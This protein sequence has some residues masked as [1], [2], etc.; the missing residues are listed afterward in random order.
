MLPVVF[1]LF[2]CRRVSSLYDMLLNAG[3]FF[4]Q[5]GKYHAGDL[6]FAEIQRT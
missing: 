3:Y 2:S 5:A 1:W 6:N 4:S